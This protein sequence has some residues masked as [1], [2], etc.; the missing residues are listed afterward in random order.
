MKEKE[1]NQSINPNLLAKTKKKKLVDIDFLFEGIKAGDWL[2]LSQAITL[3]E[4][5]SSS[6][7]K[8]AQN[9]IKRCLPLSG[10]SFRIGIT[11]SPGVGKSTFIEALGMQLIELGHKVA[12]LAID[13]SSSI[14][15]GSILG[16]K[17]RMDR[18][19]ANE[20]AFIRPSPAGESLGG[21]AR[22]TRESI[23]LC[24]AA[25]YNRILVETVGVGQSEIAVHSMVDFF[26]L[27]L[28]P[29]GGD[30]LQGIK[31][32]V[33]EM[34]DLIVIN[35][36]DGDRTLIAEK[37]KRSVQNALHI[38]PPGN[39]EWKTPVETISALKQ[40][41]IESVIV[42]ADQYL[43]HIQTLS[44][45]E[46]NR[47]EQ[48]VYLLDEYILFRLKNT[49]Y[50]DNNITERYN[51]IKEKVRSNKVTPFDAADELFQIFLDSHL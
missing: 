5:K 15:K 13:P 9:L 26:L 25:G 11:G 45:F 28:L 22:T 6:D 4:S 48:A 44:I 19:S 24:E 50:Q 38:L 18:L 17:T 7:R 27:M 35:K 16:D 31:R 21:V 33:M 43:S 8:L 40:K 47:K 39:K 49:F 32:G 20:N 1:K 37:S 51:E 12:V 46:K 23:I 41:N 14:N 42:L 30:E 2:A 3:V 10:N 34:A 36:A 29:G